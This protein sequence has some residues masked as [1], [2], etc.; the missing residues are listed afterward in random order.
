[1]HAIYDIG[2]NIYIVHIC[3]YSVVSLGRPTLHAF[4]WL[5]GVRSTS[6]TGKRIT[7]VTMGVF[8]CRDDRWIQLLGMELP[9]HWDKTMKALGMQDQIVWVDILT[10]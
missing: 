8:R 10:R 4:V 1:M 5:K 2:I 3:F 9:K 6:E 7:T